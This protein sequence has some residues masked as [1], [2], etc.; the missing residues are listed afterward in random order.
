VQL[1]T[2]KENKGEDDDDDQLPTVNRRLV[3]IRALYYSLSGR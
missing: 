3:F 2:V 1:L